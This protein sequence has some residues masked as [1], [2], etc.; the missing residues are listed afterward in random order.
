MTGVSGPGAGRLTECWPD[1]RQPI[2]APLELHEATVRDD[3]VD[4]NDHLSE[5]AYLL[6]FGDSSDAFFRYIGVDEAYR[7]SGRSLYT[8]ETHLRHLREVKLHQQ[9]TLTLQLLGVDSRRL[10]LLHQMYQGSECTATA[11]QLLLHVDTRA[12]RVAAFSAQL[13]ARLECI[14]LAHAELA[15][16]AFVGRPIRAP[17]GGAGHG[18]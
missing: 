11:E 14:A 9:L 2:A 10:H 3:W 12:G 6:I 17:D 13:A 4:Y 1:D 7:A 8:A 15:V 5:W 18:S 16:P